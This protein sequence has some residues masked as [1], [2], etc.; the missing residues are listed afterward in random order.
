[1]AA[2]GVDCQNIKFP[3]LSTLGFKLIN[4]TFYDDNRLGVSRSYE[5][6]KGP[7]F[8]FYSF[9]NGYDFINQEVL[10]YFLASGVGDII[11]SYK[12]PENSNFQLQDDARY[13]NMD[14]FN[15]F[16][17]Q[18][19][20]NQG[21]FMTAVGGVSTGVATTLDII[22]IGTDGK[23]MYKVRSSTFIPLVQKNNL[24]NFIQDFEY[25]LIDFYRSFIAIN[26]TSILTSNVVWSGSNDDYLIGLEAAK[27]GDFAT[28]LREWEPLAE[29]GDPNA[30]YNLGV[31]Y[32]YGHGVSQDYKTAIKFYSLAAYQGHANAQNSLGNM[33]S[34]GEGVP[35]NYKTAIK[36]YTL[37]GE[38]GNSDAQNSLGVMYE[39]GYGVV[40]DN[41]TAI[42]W[43]T[44]AAEQDDVNALYNLGLM[45]S[46][47]IVVPKDYKTA[48][49]WYTLAA[50]QGNTNAQSYLGYMYRT[51]QGV[52]QNYKTAVKWFTLAAEQGE[53]HSQSNLGNMYRTG[54]GV[55]QNYKTAVKWYRLAAEQGNTISQL[56][57][58]LSYATGKGVIKNDVYAYMW[59]HIS[60][61]NEEGNGSE[62]RDKLAQ[63][64]T[65]AEIATAQ[66]LARECVAKNY[67]GC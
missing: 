19:F 12:R 2:Q 46:Q 7:I 30:Q 40:Q 48:L 20:I 24:K 62:A 10:D 41:K 31:M 3:N 28:A 59:L 35:Q 64:M 29:Q 42:K 67:K 1:M 44:L 52:A 21:V 36:W 15:E 65:A 13:L 9:D 51:G 32:Y 27:K 61:P 43:Y 5:H 6:S 63:E 14:K 25:I 39:N 50:E 55:A 56:N 18:E 33:Y 16:G 4:E 57:L 23:C 47:G 66:K 54:Q 58:G 38:Q 49:K 11:E 60:D 37:A 34:R 26:D 17:M 22:T 53:S 8:T 45:Y